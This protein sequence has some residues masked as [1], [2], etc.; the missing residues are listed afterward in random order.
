MSTATSLTQFESTLGQTVY[1][2]HGDR[3]MSELI[4][5]L[6]ERFALLGVLEEFFWRH[7]QLPARRLSRK[8]S[9]L[10]L[11][12]TSPA[13]RKK[14]HERKHG[15]D[16]FEHFARLCR[17]NTGSHFLDSGGAYGYHYQKPLPKEN[18]N[19]VTLRLGYSREEVECSLSLA[20]VLYAFCKNT[21]EIESLQAE[22]EA[23][24][25][26]PENEEES[27]LANIEEF[28][29]S[30]E[31]VSE[32]HTFNSYNGDSDLDQV[33]QGIFFTLHVCGEKHGRACIAVQPHCGCDVRGGYPKPELYELT[34]PDYFYGALGLLEFNCT[35]EECHLGIEY[36]SVYDL[37]RKLGDE[38]LKF[39][40]Y[41]RRLR[42][43]IKRFR[44]FS[45][46]HSHSHSLYGQYHSR[47]FPL[48]RFA[49]SLE[50]AQRFVS[51]HRYDNTKTPL[52]VKVKQLLYRF[53][54]KL[55]TRVSLPYPVFS[56]PKSELIKKITCPCGGEVYVNNPCEY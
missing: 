52:S 6:K 38:E 17:T 1:Y 33:L 49:Q 9:R 27:W 5:K 43:K 45:K 29:E 10:F 31:C 8:V 40:V 7:F 53:T 42:V 28:L 16:S 26:L 11:Y 41:P 3:S 44:P 35:N 37:D 55:Y 19:P 54:V 18:D 51:A 50:D 21:P 14:E 4:W 56:F 12:T 25:K 13:F 20:H 32:V 46:W 15:R 36:S 22:F 30:H 48:G 39:T 47:H 2:K 34:E 24:A 23:F